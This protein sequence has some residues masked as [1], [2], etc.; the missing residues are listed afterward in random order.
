MNADFRVE[1]LVGEE[2]QIFTQAVVLNRRMFQ[3]DQKLLRGENLCVRAQFKHG[4]V[5]LATRRLVTLP[6]SWDRI[7]E[8]AP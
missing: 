1:V 5:D 3:I 7:F 4:L 2:I 8:T 6:S